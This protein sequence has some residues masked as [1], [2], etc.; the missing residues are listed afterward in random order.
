MKILLLLAAALFTRF[1]QE[2]LVD[3]KPL[4]P[5]PFLPAGGSIAHYKKGYDLF[6][7]KCKSPTDAAIVL[8]NWK[9]AMTD[10][11]FVASFG[12]YFG[13]DG[14]KPVFIFSKGAWVAGVAGL[15]EKE[16]D[17]QGRTLAGRLD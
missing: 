16:A 9:K 15:N 11:K 17:L 4:P 10:P 7:V 6:V 5:R 14:G 2:N 1:P 12:G 3:T 13:K 8:L